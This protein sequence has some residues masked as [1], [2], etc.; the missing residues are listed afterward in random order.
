MIKKEVTKWSHE[1]AFLE[2]ERAGTEKN[3]EGSLTVQLIVVQ[4]QPFQIR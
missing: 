2:Q 3:N 4:I 1:D